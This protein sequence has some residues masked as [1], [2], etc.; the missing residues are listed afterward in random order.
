MNRFIQTIVIALCVAASVALSVASEEQIPPHLQQ[1]M[2]IAHQIDAD[3]NEYAHKGCFIKWK[4]EDGATI[5]ENRSD[6]SDFLD[7][8]LEH[9]YHFTPQQMKGWTGHERPYATNWY[10]IVHTGNGF[11][12][13]S[14]AESIRPG[15]VLAI[16]FPPGMADTGHIMLAASVARH[17]SATA[18]IEPGTQQ[19]ELD[20]IDSS[21]SGHGKADTR[22]KPDGTFAHGVGEGTIR[23]YSNADGVITG[24]SWSTGGA[25]NFEPVSEHKL[26]VGRLQ[27]RN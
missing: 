14:E 25:S 19:W 11:N 6:C 17:R 26:A 18:P 3:H 15:D 24:Y 13:I 4:G 7:L 9:T 21:K 12:V 1:A 23:L 20:V 2:L 22:R 16:K 10:D 5:Y 8:L 27:P